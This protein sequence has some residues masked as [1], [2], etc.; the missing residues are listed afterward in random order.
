MQT[1]VAAVDCG[2]NS[3]RLLVADREGRAIERLMRITRL[4]QGVDRTGRLAPDAIERTIAV[5]SEYRGVM[6]RLGAGPVRMAATSAARDAANRDEFFERAA[7]AV[8]V[9]PELLGGDAEGALSFAGATAELDPGTGPWLIADIGG[10]STEL[11]VGGSPGTEPDAVTSVDVG[12]VRITERF[13]GGDPPEAPAIAAARDQVLDVLRDASSR[14]PQLAGAATLVGLAGTVACLAATDQQL[15]SYDRDRVHHYRLTRSRV[16]GLLRDLAADTAEVRARRP[17]MEKGR[18]DVIVGGTIVLAALM[19]H[20]GF[21]ECLTSEAD[22]LDG[23]VMSLLAP[24]SGA[25]P[26][27]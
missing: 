14:H 20:F 7:S 13:L 9:E 15:G 6:D 27:V 17:G 22:I 26:A 25:D 24:R 16:E 23:M 2:T 8:G 18:V 5:L 1:S 21:D 4:G 10:G 19:E 11:A 12:C 3:T